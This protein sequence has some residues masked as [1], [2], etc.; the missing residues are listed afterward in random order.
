MASSSGR[1]TGRQQRNTNDTVPI[2]IG[3]TLL[4]AVDNSV[5]DALHET[6]S[7][8][9]SQ[10]TRRNYRCRIS[11]IIQHFKDHFPEYYQIGVRQLTQEEISDRTKYFFNKT[12]DLIYTGLNVQ[13]LMYFLSSTDKRAD[14]KLKSHEDLRKYRDSVLWGAKVAGQHLPSSFYDA[15]EVYLAAYKK[16]FATAKNKDM[17]MSTA[18]TQSPC[19]FIDFCF[20]GRSKRTMYLRGHGRYC[21]GIAWQGALPLT[22]WHSTTLV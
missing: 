19:P 21:N 6:I 12:E 5:N 18:L 20:A 8:G 3:S 2:I 17:W 4:P 13:F 14:G 16:K 7:Q 15:M 22:A 10:A 9:M 11:K 1:S